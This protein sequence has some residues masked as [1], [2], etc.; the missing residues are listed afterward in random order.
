MGSRNRRGRTFA[1]IYPAVQRKSMRRQPRGCERVVT[2]LVATSPLRWNLAC[3]ILRN[4]I[5]PAGSIALPESA[6]YTAPFPLTCAR[7]QE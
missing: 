7:S 5:F 1:R 4:F 3:G 2:S 6:C